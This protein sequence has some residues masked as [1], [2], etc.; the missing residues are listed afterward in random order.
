MPSKYTDS[1][2][3]PYWSFKPLPFWQSVFAGGTYTANL[4][5]CPWT[6]RNCWSKF[7][8]RRAEPNYE[9]EPHE[10][11][12]KLVKGIRRNAQCGARLTGGEPALYW[13]HTRGVIREF[14]ERTQDVRIHIPGETGRRGDPVGIVVE[15]NGAVAL[16][17]E[18]LDELEAEFGRDAQR[19]V[20]HLGIKATSPEQLAEL[21][22]MTHATCVRFHEQQLA[23]LMHG[24]YNIK[25]LVI[26]ASFL[27]RFTDPGIYAAILREV[28]RARPGMSRNV[29]VLDFKE[30]SGTTR[31]YVPKRLRGDTPDDPGAED[32]E[33][34]NA[35]VTR[36]GG[37]RRPVERNEDAG[38]PTTA[39]EELAP[40]DLS[41]R[42]DIAEAFDDAVREQGIPDGTLRR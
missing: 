32:P 19:V 35:L 29:N 3:A 33:V 23:N 25:H 38:E 15:T 40:E 8:W 7:G 20:I 27:D 11:A 34:I 6:C 13:E 12:E 5:G 9:L 28:E 14:L 16:V 36:D 42:V 18:R 4:M 41:E 22:G 24:A 10:V 26:H 37:L 31:L 1:T 17:P 39:I 2:L 21:T 30:Y